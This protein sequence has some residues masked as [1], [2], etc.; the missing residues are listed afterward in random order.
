[1]CCCI[2]VISQLE[3]GNHSGETC[4]AW[5]YVCTTSS[6][7]LRPHNGT[8]SDCS[9]QVLLPH[10]SLF[11]YILN[12]LSSV[13]SL[14]FVLLFLGSE[15]SWLCGS[16]LLM[17]GS[18]GLVWGCQRWLW[19]CRNL[20]EFDIRFSML[21]VRFIQVFLRCCPACSRTSGP[22]KHCSLS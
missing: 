16:K 10:R 14:L 9:S 2:A 5:P 12:R 18:W 17:V 11:S 6:N 15:F 19:F 8:I 3:C 21:F 7:L 1:M 13:R 22:L 20:S 4:P